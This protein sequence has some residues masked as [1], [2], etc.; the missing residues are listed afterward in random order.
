MN[1]FF[2]IFFRDV[3]VG[4][5]HL[6]TTSQ[7]LRFWNDGLLSE[8]FEMILS[9]LAYCCNW[10]DG[11]LGMIRTDPA[12]YFAYLFQLIFRLWN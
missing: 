2:F 12:S 5:E 7:T 1:R 3:N 11:L 6:I 8:C 10:N 9:G 4:D